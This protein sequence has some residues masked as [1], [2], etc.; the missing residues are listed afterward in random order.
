MPGPV[1]WQTAAGVFHLLGAAVLA[2]VV[3]AVVL[4]RRRTRKTG[5][6]Q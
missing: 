2:G 1:I 5:G 3:V 4:Y 6:V